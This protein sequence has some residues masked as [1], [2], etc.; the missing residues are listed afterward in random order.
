LEKF[1]E[2][3]NK[4]TKKWRTTETLPVIIAGHPLIA[5]AYLRWIF[6]IQDQFPTI[7]IELDHHY[8]NGKSTKIKISE[9]LLW[10][11]E[12]ADREEMAECHLIDSM[13]TD[14]REFAESADDAIDLLD[15]ETWGNYSFSRAEDLIWISIA[16]RAAHQQRVENLVQ[17]AGHLGKTH[18]E[19]ARRSARAKIHC[20]FF[21]DFNTWALHLLHQRDELELIE[22]INNQRRT[23]QLR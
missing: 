20:I 5:K 9:C 14:L 21:R 10:L 7:E 11:T 19:E 23:R 15:R 3:L 22:S 13:Y 1:D 18:V 4:H 12:N 8:M 16:P 6:N 17:T 2:Q